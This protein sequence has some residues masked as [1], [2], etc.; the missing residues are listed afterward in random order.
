MTEPKSFS[1]KEDLGSQIS[2][3][4]TPSDAEM[5]AKLLTKTSNLVSINATQASKP[6]TAKHSLNGD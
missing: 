3:M 4:V 2:E 5:A 6:S 1:L